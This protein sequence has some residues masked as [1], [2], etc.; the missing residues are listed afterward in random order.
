MGLFREVSDISSTIKDLKCRSPELS[1]SRDYDVVKKEEDDL[2]TRVNAL[3]REKDHCQSL[4]IEHQTRLNNLD[5]EKTKLLEDKILTQKNQ[6]DRTAKHLSI[7][8]SLYLS[9]SL[10][11]YLSISLSLYLS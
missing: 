1:N 6:L 3:R 11:L 9:I 8:L 5:R 10:S 4:E 2:S 7:S